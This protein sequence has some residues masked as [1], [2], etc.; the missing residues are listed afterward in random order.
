MREQALGQWR[1]HLRADGKGTGGLAEDGYIVRVAAKGRDVAPHPLDGSQ[2]IQQSIVAGCVMG[3]L[4]GQLLGGEKPKNPQPVIHGDHHHPF[5]GEVFAVLTRLRGATAGKPAAKNPD[6][7]RQFALGFGGGCPHVEGE[8]I[9]ALTRIAEDHVVKMFLLDNTGTRS[10]WLWRTPCHLAAGCG[11][12]QRSGPTGGAAKG[13][14]RKSRAC[15]S[16]LIFP[17][18]LP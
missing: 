6:H 17:W 10:W 9:L 15:P 3:I 12:F 16:A 5:A 1:C 2:F 11:G 14:P 7:Y 8:A 13:M 18:T 4:G